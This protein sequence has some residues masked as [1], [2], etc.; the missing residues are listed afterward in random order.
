MLRQ[1]RNNCLEQMEQNG[2][3]GTDGYEF[4]GQVCKDEK[5][6]TLSPEMFLE[7]RNLMLMS[8]IPKK[9]NAAENEQTAYLRAA[10]V[11]VNIFKNYFLK[12]FFLK[13]SKKTLLKL[14]I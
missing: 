7:I 14:Y 2:F 9:L 6:E 8:I 13:K 5:S 11:R 1:S 4:D 3:R 10:I 12:L